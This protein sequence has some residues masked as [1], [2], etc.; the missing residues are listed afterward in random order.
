MPYSFLFEIFFLRCTFSACFCIIFSSQ[1]VLG[2]PKESQVSF[3]ST[4]ECTR[5]LSSCVTPRRPRYCPPRLP[6]SG[7]PLLVLFPKQYCSL[8][9]AS[10]PRELDQ[11]YLGTSRRRLRRR[12]LCFQLLALHSP[13]CFPYFTLS[14]YFSPLPSQESPRRKA[15]T[16]TNFQEEGAAPLP[17]PAT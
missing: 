14:S 8:F 11:K 15:Q 2:L 6:A 12:S 1:I 4:S 7:I 10:R 5:L 9:S 17:S 16:N 13:S 3:K